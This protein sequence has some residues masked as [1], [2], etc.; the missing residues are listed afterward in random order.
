MEMIQF[1]TRVV[2]LDS[3]PERW[4][5]IPPEMD[6]IGITD[7]ERF[8]AF[9]NG[10]EGSVKSHIE[11]LKNVSGNLLVCE[12]DVCFIDQAREIF[13]LAVS[14]LPEDWDMLYLGANPKIP[15]IRHSDHL[16]KSE[17]G[18]HTN[19]AIL[20]TEKARNYVFANY[21]YN[22]MDYYDHWLFMVG[23]K[24]MNVFLVSPMIAWQSPGYSDCR[25]DYMDYYL[26]MRSN[27][28]RHM[29]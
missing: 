13:E 6:K 9:E 15:Q 11:V 20:Y 28:I 22:T 4:K 23:Q 25:R 5:K 19:H 21:D 24:V 26:H 10:S 16:F 8:S 12:D 2:N 18:V 7:Y 29:I 14:E 27:E 17:G 1:K 3:R